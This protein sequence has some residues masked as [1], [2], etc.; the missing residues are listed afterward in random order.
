[1]AISG[2]GAEATNI[3][4]GKD[5]AYVSG[6][7]L[8]SAARIAIDAE[9]AS[10]ITAKIIAASAS[11]GIGVGCGRGRCRSA[12]AVAE[13]FIGYDAGGNMAALQVKP[14]R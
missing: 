2:A 4:L 14:T 1:M 3:I 8:T 7:N 6:S 9:D 10:E 13:N 5:N 12:S 11:V